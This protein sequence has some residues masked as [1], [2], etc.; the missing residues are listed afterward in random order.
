MN[1]LKHSD[2]ALQK[3][4]L[5]YFSGILGFDIN[6][7]QWL[8]PASYTQV[9]AGLQF[10]TRVLLLEHSL[11]LAQRNDFRGVNP[12]PL[13]RFRHIHDPYL[14]EGGEFPF[15][16]F[17]KLLNYGIHASKNSTT[18]SR[19][20]WSADNKSLFWD[21]DKLIMAE[22]KEFVLKLLAE[23]ENMCAVELLFQ[24]DGHLPQVDPYT[25]KDNPNRK[26]AEYYFGLEQPEI[27]EDGRRYIFHNLKQCEKR[28]KLF[29]VK[30]GKLKFLKAGVDDYENWVNKFKKLLCILMMVTCGQTGRGSELT[31][32]L[33]MNTMNSDRSI[34]IEDGQIMFI[35][36]YHKTQ[37]ITD[38]LKV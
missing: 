29:H 19:I 28:N 14:V 26:E 37:A 3:S 13:E 30:E 17:H 1:F 2:F 4:S 7:H 18:R 36:K 5:I 8:E 6:L 15:N 38:S 33:Y 11:P 16:Y 10:C 20:R 22:W 24:S 23:A 27:L 34:Y 31:S 25:L 12:T 21:G 32:L 35:T 9:L